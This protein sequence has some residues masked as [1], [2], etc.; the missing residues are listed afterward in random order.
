MCWNLPE[1]NNDLPGGPGY[2]EPE[3]V[4]NYQNQE[5][6]YIEE[7]GSIS[8][9]I[10]FWYENKNDCAIGHPEFECKPIVIEPGTE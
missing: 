6:W 4:C 8:M 1:G 7:T 2:K 5:I 3:M 10:D 9:T